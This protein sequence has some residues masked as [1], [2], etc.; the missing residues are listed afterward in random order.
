MLLNNT[1]LETRIQQLIDGLFF[2][3]K[4]LVSTCSTC[5]NWVGVY[6][7][8]E[9]LSNLKI[10]VKNKWKF[11]TLFTIMIWQ[12]KDLVKTIFNKIILCDHCWHDL[13]LY[14][15]K[16]LTNREMVNFQKGDFF[17]FSL[18]FYYQLFQH[19]TFLTYCRVY[20]FKIWALWHANF[21]RTKAQCFAL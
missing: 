14:I 11:G 18:Y 4:D 8:A 5:S 1:F 13:H 17:R 19:R 15:W 3:D 12:I 16:M 7:L 2:V 21:S 6:I 20:I 10:F 9:N